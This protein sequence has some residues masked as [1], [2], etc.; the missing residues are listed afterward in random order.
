MQALFLF[1]LLFSNGPFKLLHKKGQ[2][3]LVPY[4][5]VEFQVILWYFKMPTH[6]F[7]NNITFF[8]IWLLSE[9]SSGSRRKKKDF[10][11]STDDY[12]YHTAL[13]CPMFTVWNDLVVQMLW[14]F[15]CTSLGRDPANTN[16][17]RVRLF[18]VSCTSDVKVSDALS[19]LHKVAQIP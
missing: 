16:T 6:M 3:V 14:L 2:N 19:C 11:A 5:R 7:K 17:N 4:C 10:A 9:L 8:N 12:C 1:T 18:D 13:S 15:N